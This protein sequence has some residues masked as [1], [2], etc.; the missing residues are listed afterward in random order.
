MI[1]IWRQL[2]WKEWHE[3]VWTIVS[4]TA[5]VFAVEAYCFFSDATAGLAQ[6]GL[7]LL[8]GVPGAF[9]VAIGVAAGERT[10][11]SLDFLRSLPL[12]RWKWAVVRLTLG[13]IASLLPVVVA[14]GAMLL[15]ASAIRSAADVPRYLVVSALSALCCVSVYAWTVAAGVRQAS[16]LRAGLAAIC[17]FVGWFVLVMLGNP[18]SVELNRLTA[19]LVLVSP[20]GISRFPDPASPSPVDSFT[21]FQV[22]SA[23][24][25]G[26]VATSCWFVRRYAA[27]TTADNRSPA[28]T[29]VV[30]FTALRPALPSPLA[31]MIWKEYREAWPMCLAGLVIVAAILLPQTVGA[32]ETEHAQVSGVAA[33]FIVFL[34]TIMA[35]VLGVGGPAADLEAGVWQ[36]WRSRPIHP[37]SWFWLKYVTGVVVLILAFDGALAAIDLL[38]G[39]LGFL[40]RDGLWW[41][42]PL[43]HLL[44]YSAAVWMVCQVRQP[45]YAGILALAI[46]ISLL[47][48]GEYPVDRPL[49]PRLGVSQLDTCRQLPLELS[50][51]PVLNWLVTTYLP[52]AAPMVAISAAFALL[53]WFAVRRSTV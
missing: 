3:Q 29:Q 24:L 47:I 21:A 52:F 26:L 16:E 28:A 14:A 12:A 4:L 46:V 20:V 31:A 8:C 40:L 34:G 37:A 38:A 32:A 43:V 6:L 45:I 33:R 42:G 48:L 15:L 18:S 51:S 23:Q 13:A 39:G 49:L 1:A 36:F 30:A 19:L 22:L 5:I 50:L 10:A 9:F 17:L 11:G 27:M 2:I 7:G 53:G 25:A 35:L 44:A 41:F